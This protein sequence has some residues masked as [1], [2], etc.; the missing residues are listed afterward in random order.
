MSLKSEL[1]AFIDDRE[2][3]MVE[4]PQ[5][6]GLSVG[7]LESQVMLLEEIRALALRDGKQHFGFTTRY[8]EFTTKRGFGSMSFAHPPGS[9]VELTP[10]TLARLQ[11]F[12]SFLAEFLADCDS[13]QA[14]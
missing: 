3:H 4:R 1:L 7:N 2:R 10:P 12:A 13:E 8:D 6:Y 9:A 11:S 14:P 5:M